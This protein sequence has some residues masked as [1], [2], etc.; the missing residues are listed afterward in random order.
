MAKS[1]TERYYYLYQLSL[2]QSGAAFLSNN[3]RLCTIL[4]QGDSM[5]RCHPQNVCKLFIIE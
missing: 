3:V 5:T 1:R 4:Q 2:P